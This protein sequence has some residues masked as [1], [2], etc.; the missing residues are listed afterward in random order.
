MFEHWKI[1]TNTIQKLQDS[2]TES[3]ME[4][5]GSNFAFAHF[6][7]F[8]QHIFFLLICHINYFVGFCL[9]LPSK[10]YQLLPCLN[11]PKFIDFQ[12]ITYLLCSL[13]NFKAIAPS[14]SS[15][16]VLLFVLF[17]VYEAF[18]V[19]FTNQLLFH[20]HSGPRI[21]IYCWLWLE[22]SVAN[23]PH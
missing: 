13:I 18:H 16:D 6:E 14:M 12:S 2:F 7:K 20:L 21:I 17:L 10:V 22:T 5:E 4:T 15:P 9:F 19:G 1:S 23:I 11:I 8:T 3:T